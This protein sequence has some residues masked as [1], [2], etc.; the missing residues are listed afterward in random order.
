MQSVFQRFPRMVRDIAKAQGKQIEIKVVG[1][2]TELDKQVAEK[3]GDP[4]VHLI[5]NSADHGS[6]RP[7][8]DGQP[9][10]AARV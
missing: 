9:E 4:L 2:E 1:E 5:R 6:S 3:L 8:C 10:R 7:T